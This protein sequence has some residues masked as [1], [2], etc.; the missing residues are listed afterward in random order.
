MPTDNDK[1]TT[2][3]SKITPFCDVSYFTQSNTRI[4]HRRPYREA[5]NVLCFRLRF[6]CV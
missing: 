6:K 4:H 2:R 3:K 5:T 1:D